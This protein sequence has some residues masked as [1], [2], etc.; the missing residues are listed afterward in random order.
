MKYVKQIT[1]ILLVSFIGEFIHS[2]IPLPVP[3]SIYGLVIMLAAL[4]SGI[5]K[6]SSVK[7]TAAFL[8]DIMPVMFIPAAAGLMT[9]WPIIKQ[10]LFV[11]IFLTVVSFAVVMTV[12]GRV[13]QRVIRMEKKK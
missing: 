6:V 3:A 2:V 7:E 4:M 11:Y 12:S 9:S 8:I 1:L 10:R 5:I 13:T